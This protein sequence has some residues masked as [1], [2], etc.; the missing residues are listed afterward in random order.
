M[1]CPGEL[2]RLN[3]GLSCHHKTQVESCNGPMRQVP[4]VM[5][6]EGG[7]F[8]PCTRLQHQGDSEVLL[9]KK[10]RSNTPGFPSSR[11]RV[12]NGPPRELVRLRYRLLEP[13][14][15]RILRDLLSDTSCSD[16]QPLTSRTMCS[17]AVQVT[18]DRPHT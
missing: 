8:V 6:R 18:P 14:G 17:S 3:Q 7:V 2:P 4:K 1:V 15:D 10:R 12:R 16:E 11:R 9:K 5:T 13:E